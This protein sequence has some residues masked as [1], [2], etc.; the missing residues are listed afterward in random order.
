MFQNYITDHIAKTATLRS[1]YQPARLATP[2]FRTMY[3]AQRYRADITLDGSIDT[4][5]NYSYASFGLAVA[6]PEM[7]GP[8]ILSYQMAF[9]I[10][11]FA[12][13][14][15]PFLLDFQSSTPLVDNSG[16]QFT[17]L[18]ADDCVLFLPPTSVASDTVCGNIAAVGRVL[19]DTR[20]D[21]AVSGTLYRSFIVGLNCKADAPLPIKGSLS[22]SLH[23]ADARFFQPAK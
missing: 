14:L 6:D 15:T 21:S 4:N 23:H 9:T 10:R 13:E 5:A 22:V 1:G 7:R 17:D 2:H 11:G 19:V 20:L 8:M 18:N 16:I 3:A 12:T